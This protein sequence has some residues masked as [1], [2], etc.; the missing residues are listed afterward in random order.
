M[1]KKPVNAKLMFMQTPNMKKWLT[2]L[3][4]LSKTG[5]D[6]AVKAA[7]LESKRLVTEKLQ[8]RMEIHNRTGITADSLDTEQKVYVTGYEYSVD[9]GFHI[10]RGGLPSIFLMHGTP[11][12]TPDTQLYDAVFGKGTQRE[13]RNIQ[14]THV[15]RVI[16]KYLGDLTE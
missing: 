2:D 11:K 6:E 1:A 8:A 15:K 7:L 9:V 14:H 13:I 3:D 5:L 12:Q 10:S 4:T 16:Q